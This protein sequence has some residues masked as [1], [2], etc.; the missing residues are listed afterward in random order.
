MSIQFK[1]SSTAG[2]APAV[3]DVKQGEIVINLPDKKIYT[4]DN[5]NAVINIGF[6]KSEADTTYVPIT[7]TTL[8]GALKGYSTTASFPTELTPK[9]YVDS[10]VNSTANTVTSNISSWKTWL[11]IA[12]GTMTGRL[13][14]NGLSPTYD[15]EAVSKAYVQNNYFP[16]T[17]GSINGVI[18]L[19]SSTPF[20]DFHYNNSS[21]DYTS[22]IIA[23]DANTL[24]LVSGSVSVSNNLTV[25]SQLTANVVQG[26]YIHSTGDLHGDGNTYTNNI[27]VNG[28]VQGSY[29]HIAGSATVDSQMRAAGYRSNSGFT[30][31]NSNNSGYAFENNGDSGLFYEGETTTAGGGTLTLRNDSGLYLSLAGGTTVS[32]APFNPRGGLFTGSVNATNETMYS[33]GGAIELYSSTPYIDFHYANTQADYTA[34]LICYD[35]G[36]Y[37][38]GHPRS[39][40]GSSPAYGDELVT[41]NY[42]DAKVASGSSVAPVTGIRLVPAGSSTSATMS[43]SQTSGSTSSSAGRVVTS[44]YATTVSWSGGSSSSYGASSGVGARYAYIQACIN[45]TWATI[46]GTG[47]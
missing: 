33:A 18:E 1:R 38:S 36:L 46:S 3:S 20:I 17:G 37:F 6:S 23:T 2:L 11:P 41:K 27:Y 4:L 25:S 8:T 14:L 34:R 26:A 29:A 32:N 47:S 24:Q 13:I 39:A 22:R 7:G 44:A 5:S 12:G 10:L 16:N 42:V 15:N 40:G 19:Y 28:T 30:A 43:G 35:T 31:N 9:Q 21:A 45:G